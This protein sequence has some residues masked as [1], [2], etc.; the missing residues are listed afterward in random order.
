MSP[1]E[2]KL[3]S[4][5]DVSPRSEAPEK[6]IQHLGAF[7][8]HWALHKRQCDKTGRNVISVF[9]PECS[10]PVWHRETWF[11]QANPPHSN[12]NFSEKFFPQAEKL[13]KQCPI[14]HSSGLN[15]E[16]CEYTD[17]WWFSRN[18][19][20][21]HSG[22]RCEDCRYSYRVLDCKNLLYCAFSFESEWCVD[23]VNSEKC[24]Q[25]RYGLY[26]R[27]C[28][29]CDFCYDCRNCHD[30]ILCSNLRNKQYC[31]GNKQFSK[32]EYEVQK[33]AF[34]FHTRGGYEI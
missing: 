11:Q 1:L 16:N 15:N 20:L 7:W 25:C 29:N 3:R 10:Y 30:C 19:Y 32:E 22:V 2:T 33:K 21:S 14:P 6:I 34:S 26:L 9:R 8:P 13:F 12:F 23:L 28:H 24:Y 17:D 18:C 27:N 4:L 31:I 5:F